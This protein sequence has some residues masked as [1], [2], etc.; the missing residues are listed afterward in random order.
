MYL[1]VHSLQELVPEL[2]PTVQCL[3]SEVHPWE[4]KSFSHY[5]DCRHTAAC[6]SQP[7]R[8]GF[9]RNKM[10]TSGT[11]LWEYPPSQQ[12]SWG[13]AASPTAGDPKVLN[14]SWGLKRDRKNADL[15]GPLVFAFS[16]PDIPT[17]PYENPWQQRE[18]GSGASGEG[19]K[20]LEEHAWVSRLGSMQAPQCSPFEGA[21]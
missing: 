15:N 18:C 7:D 13:E 4:V 12:R 19:C 10:K 16:P 1:Q 14:L 11:L 3:G 17:Q 9:W 21:F 20:W 2:T 8:T 6:G 5:E